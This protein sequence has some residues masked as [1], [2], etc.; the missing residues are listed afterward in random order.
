MSDEIVQL[1]DQA[2]SQFTGTKQDA[3]ALIAMHKAYLD[4]NSAGLDGE[5]LQK[6]WSHDP[7]C[8][9]F[10]GTGYNYYG[11]EDWLKLW[12]YFGPRCDILEPWRSSDV[13]LIGN[14]EVCVVTSVRT[15]RGRWKSSSEQPDWTGENW[16]SRSTEVFVRENG[17]WRCVHIHIS[18]QA[19]GV[20]HEQR[21]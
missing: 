11:I 14:G 8:V 13:R 18:T 5:A 4:A 6:I 10:N 19:E 2:F 15:A 12:A 3:D 21:D 16:P 9:W 1:S 7:D 17:E 20:R